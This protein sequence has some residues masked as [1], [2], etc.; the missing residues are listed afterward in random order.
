MR[1]AEEGSSAFNVIQ[2]AAGRICGALVR[3][4]GQQ[5]CDAAAAKQCEMEEPTRTTHAI[6]KSMSEAKN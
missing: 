1:R 6:H 2:S 3:S 5:W 4:T